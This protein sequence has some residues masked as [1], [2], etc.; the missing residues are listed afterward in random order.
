MQTKKGALIVGQFVP[1]VFR[2]LRRASQRTWSR[3]RSQT[4]SV[5]TTLPAQSSSSSRLSRSSCRCLATSRA[6]SFAW[7]GC[8]PGCSLGRSVRPAA[9]VEHLGGMARGRLQS[10]PCVPGWH[11]MPCNALTP[12]VFVLSSAPNFLCML[13]LVL[14]KKHFVRAGRIVQRVGVCGAGARARRA[15]GPVQEDAG[16][17]K[18]AET[19]HFACGRVS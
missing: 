16:H 14:Y 13:Q 7:C 3:A 19:T 17:G 10:L 4:T 2:R 15:P 8:L 9:A 12:V 11:A 1:M 6:L 18:D 5:Q